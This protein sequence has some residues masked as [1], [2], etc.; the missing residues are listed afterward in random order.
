MTT[1]LLLLTVCLSSSA[2]AQGLFTPALKQYAQTVTVTQPIVVKSGHV[3]DGRHSNGK[4]TRYV[5][6]RNMGDGSQREDQKPLF[7]L[8]PGAKL[9]NIILD[10][11]S[12]DGIHAHASGGRTTRI[13]NVQVRD[14]GEDAITIKSGTSSGRVIIYRCSFLRA[15]DKVIQI[16]A[17]ANVVVDKCYAQNFTRF[18]RTTGTGPNKAYRITITD[19]GFRNGH[20]ILKMT[21]SKARGSLTNVRYENIKHVVETDNGADAKLRN[22]DEHEERRGL[23]GRRRG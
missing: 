8:E 13:Q 9:Q 2:L 3:H 20:T 5:A 7:I 4:L 17:P 21:N 18:A 19:S 22:V 1:R 12:A 15:A 6:A 16:N 10:R 11:P 23:F 14:V